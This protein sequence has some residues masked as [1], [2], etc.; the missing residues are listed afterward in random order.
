MP[1]FTSH[2]TPLTHKQLMQIRQENK[3]RQST[4]KN[5]GCNNQKAG[6]SSRCKPCSDKFRN[7]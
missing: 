7:Q 4:C 6:G 5:E 1:I 2:K 3:L